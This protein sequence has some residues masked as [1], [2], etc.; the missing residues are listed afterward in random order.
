MM[1]SVPR[2]DLP[3]QALATG[4]LVGWREWPLA[5]AVLLVLIGFADTAASIATGWFASDTYLHGLIV[6]PVVIW[7]L[8]QRREAFLA[9]ERPAASGSTEG[10]SVA[11]EAGMP[12]SQVKRTGRAGSAHH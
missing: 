10:A 8:W 4:A 7:W 2:N 11:A 5:L 12:I 6:L 9:G 3:V 1:A